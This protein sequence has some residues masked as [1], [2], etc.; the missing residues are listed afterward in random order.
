MRVRGFVRDKSSNET[1]PQANVYVSDSKGKLLTPTKGTSTDFDGKF[2]L[3][4]LKPSDYV[5]IRYMGYKTITNKVSDLG[6]G[7]TVS[8]TFYLEPAAVEGEEFAVI[9]YRDE[10]K[11]PEPFPIDTARKKERNYKPFIIGGIA[12]L[13]IVGGIITYKVAKGKKAKK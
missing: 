8:R 13:L 4:D 6:S 5:S 1:L 11:K 2:L 7:V 10:P 12:L 9:E 3:D